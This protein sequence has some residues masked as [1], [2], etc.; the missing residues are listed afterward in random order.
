MLVAT[1]PQ[2]STIV[3]KNTSPILLRTLFSLGS[4]IAPRATIARAVR[5]FCTP[6]ASARRRAFEADEEGAQSFALD[7]G[8][9][10][11]Q[12]YQWGDPSSQAYVLIAHG[13]SDFAL[14]FL[15][16]VKTLRAAGY[17]VVTF[18]Q[19]G[20]GRSSGDTATLPDFAR[21]VGAIGRRFGRAA[22]VIGHSMGAAAAAI[23]LHDGFEADCAVLIAPPA[24]LGA[25][26]DRFADFIGLATCLRARL[27][28][29]L[30]HRASARFADLEA[31]RSVPDINRPA[32][33][34]HDL[35][36]REVPWEEGERYARYWPESR[37]ISTQGLGHNRILADGGVIDA[38]LRF[39][40]GETIG[41]RVVSSPNLPFGF[42]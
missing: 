35:N 19:P 5:I 42:A 29:A 23:A 27:H 22:A 13:W 3:R 40:R 8:A 17:A 6:S 38:M 2:K 14:R 39:L 21:S 25:A 7:V 16:L 26:A 4:W 41:E 28:S 12:V 36:D 9:H 33:I 34:I 1:S 11:V 24:D 18:D 32:L 10:R 37:M 31:H 20:H 15:P 30:E